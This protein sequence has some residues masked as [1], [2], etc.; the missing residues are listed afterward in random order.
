LP[1]SEKVRVEIF[2]PDL[3]DPIYNRILEELGDELS[4]AFGGCTV[5]QAFGKYRSASGAILPDKI[6]V[7]FTDAPFEW[8]KDRRIV[9]Q[10]VLELQ[11]VVRRALGKEEAILIAVYPIFHSQL[12]ELIRRDAL[13][14]SGL[15]ILGVLLLAVQAY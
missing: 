6:N 2:V 13:G 1:L 15:V 4:Y 10:Y 9:E 11:N 12:L 14:P 3:P 5:T 8:E 7:L